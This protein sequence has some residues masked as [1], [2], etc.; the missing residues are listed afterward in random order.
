MPANKGAESKQGLII[1]LV[2]FVLLTIILGVTTYYGYAEQDAL[3]KAAA[4]AKKDA[5]SAKKNR[6]W[7][8]Y[9]AL[10]L[11]EYTGDLT[12]QE[13]E[14]LSV[15]PG[16]STA[17]EDQAAYNALFADL[18][19]RLAKDAATI[20]PYRQKVARLEEELRNREA[21]LQAER[22]NLK[23]EREEHARAMDVKR[24]ELTQ[25]QEDLKKAQAENVADRQKSEQELLTRLQEFGDTSQELEKEKKKHATEVQTLLKE[26]KVRQ[27]ENSDLQTV[28][29]RVRKQITA[30]DLQKFSTPKGKILNVLPRGQVFINLGSADHVRT[31]QALTFSIFGSGTGGQGSTQRKGALEVIDVRGPHLSLAKITETVD[32]RTMPIQSGDVLVNP[33]WSPTM[34]EHVAIAGLID[35]A[36][37]GRDHSED[38]MRALRSQGVVID[39]YVDLREATIKGKMT[40]KTDYL[41]LGE[42]PEFNANTTVREGD[43]RFEHK[44]EI[45]T[46]IADMQTE[47]KRVGATVVP[48][49]RFVALTGYQIPQAARSTSAYSYESRVPRPSSNG[50]G[51]AA[52]KQ[53]KAKEENKD[54]SK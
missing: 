24:Q 10:K 41:I 25:A 45:L 3:R 35:L 43:S 40:F 53:E 31:Q 20:E 12:K 7:Y 11:K 4:D 46:K 51:K 44:T 19:S 48:L 15:A 30:P 22:N 17:G 2:G 23:K 33:A 27:A 13:T 21:S 54:E 16:K 36:G 26:G 52:G 9:V 38:L 50:E 14:E 29:D 8:K 32:P 47:A 49:R 39:A 37:D 6:D 18:Q 34:Q 5:D 1:T 42:Q 28:L